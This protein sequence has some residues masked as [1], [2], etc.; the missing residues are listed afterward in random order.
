MLYNDVVLTRSSEFAVKL[1]AMFSI[2]TGW[3]GI[4]IQ[5]LAQTGGCSLPGGGSLKGGFPEDSF[6]HE[7]ILSGALGSGV[8]T[9]GPVSARL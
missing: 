6:M 1:F 7:M 5:D 3:F 4:I 9:E 2:I 8:L